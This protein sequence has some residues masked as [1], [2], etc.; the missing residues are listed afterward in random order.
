M[1]NIQIPQQV[2]VPFT[3]LSKSNLQS[4]KNNDKDNL[5]FLESYYYLL[6]KKNDD[7]VKLTIE[8]LYSYERDY[9][10]SYLKNIDA[11]IRECV[12][13]ISSQY[14]IE[15][16]INE[17]SLFDLKYYLGELQ[18]TSTATSKVKPISS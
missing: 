2:F 9:I 15:V 6:F 17:T 5:N 1:L 18:I 10:F 8:P 11:I 13:P 7:V 16:L 4:T 3:D 14:Y 12:D